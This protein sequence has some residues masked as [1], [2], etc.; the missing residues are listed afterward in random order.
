MV[1]RLFR[2]G[3]SH[4]F[5]VLKCIETC[6]VPKHGLLVES[7]PLCIPWVAKCRIWWLILILTS[8]LF[9]LNFCGKWEG[10]VYLDI[11]IWV[12]SWQFLLGEFVFFLLI[13]AFLLVYLEGPVPSL[14]CTPYLRWPL[15]NLPLLILLNVL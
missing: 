7:W 6:F 3:F 14:V 1:H 10:G 9:L 15:N 4:D 2:S 8:S 11:K 13:M 12:K 5:N